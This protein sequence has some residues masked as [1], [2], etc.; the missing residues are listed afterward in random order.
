MLSAFKI[1]ENKSIRRRK[2]RR[3]LAL[4]G[5][6]ATPGYAGGRKIAYSEEKSR[7]RKNSSLKQKWFADHTTT[8]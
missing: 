5:P 4:V 2:V 1:K 3:M 6:K 8:K 7:Q